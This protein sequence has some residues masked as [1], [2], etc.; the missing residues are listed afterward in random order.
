MLYCLWCSRENN[1]NETSIIVWKRIV[2]VRTLIH[3]SQN[4]QQLAGVRRKNLQVFPTAI[5]NPNFSS[6]YCLACKCEI[7]LLVSLF[8]LWGKAWELQTLHR[9][10]MADWSHGI[11]WTSGEMSPRNGKK[12]SL[13]F[14]LQNRYTRSDMR[15]AVK[16]SKLYLILS[17]NL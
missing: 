9:S 14:C 2:S 8:Y 5:S 11:L 13:L 15:A 17:I 6:L 3:M 7:Y 4:T 12:G 10:R 16:H 1:K